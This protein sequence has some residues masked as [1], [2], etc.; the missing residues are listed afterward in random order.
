MR[1]TLPLV[2]WTHITTTATLPRGH[3]ETPTTIIHL[4]DLYRLV[5]WI[6]TKGFIWKSLRELVL[7]IATLLPCPVW[8]AT[9]DHEMIRTRSEGIVIFTITLCPLLIDD[10]ELFFRISR[11]ELYLLLVLI[12]MFKLLTCDS[13]IM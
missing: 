11:H 5:Q 10:T 7:E 2:T 8:E 1:D 6:A 9:I 12:E 3:L 4:N 13:V